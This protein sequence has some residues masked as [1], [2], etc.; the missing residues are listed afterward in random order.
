MTPLPRGSRAELGVL[1]RQ[2][3]IKRP[4]VHGEVGQ[5]T[6]DDARH[7]ETARDKER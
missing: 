3:R 2:G 4:G 6:M 7:I 5:S 1:D